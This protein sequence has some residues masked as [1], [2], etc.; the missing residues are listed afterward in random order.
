MR[1]ADSQ[2]NGQF[3]CAFNYP[4]STCCMQISPA[5]KYRE[6]LLS[7]TQNRKT[8]FSFIFRMWIKLT[9]ENKNAFP[10][11]T[12]HWV[13]WSSYGYFLPNSCSQVAR[14]LFKYSF[15]NLNTGG[16]QT[17]WDILGCLVL[18]FLLLFEFCSFFREFVQ[19][20]AECSVT[21]G[22]ANSCWI[23]PTS[24]AYLEALLRRGHTTQTLQPLK[25]VPH[26]QVY[27]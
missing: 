17:G 1:G 19:S 22:A 4:A 26:L 24:T 6:R 15:L 10:L 25:A 20:A 21:D 2:L 13:Y 12:V 8:I 14:W 7:Y 27:R 11:Y 5:F 9:T 23:W 18:Y 3:K 16:R